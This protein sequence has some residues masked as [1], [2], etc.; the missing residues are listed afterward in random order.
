MPVEFGPYR[1]EFSAMAL[2]ADRERVYV[3]SRSG[4]VV[5][6]EWSSLR[7]GAREWA[8][9]PAPP[10]PPG[11]MN[12]AAHVGSL[13]QI[14]STE[15]GLYSVACYG[16]RAELIAWEPETHARLGAVTYRERVGVVSL[17]SGPRGEQ[18]V[19]GLG[20]G[21]VRLVGVG[22]LRAASEAP[23]KRQ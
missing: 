14:L 7:S 17:T 22:E 12:L 6:A 19:L 16:T 10:A 13:A 9:F 8:R 11:K 18:L 4:D 20:S 23:R 2:S 15:S 1:A 21:G 5:W 3:G